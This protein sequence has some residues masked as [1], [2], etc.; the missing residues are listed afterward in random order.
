MSTELYDARDLA[1]Q[2]HDAARVPESKNEEVYA[3]TMQMIGTLI[4]AMD[5]AG[6]TMAEQ[7]RRMGDK[8]S[9]LVKELTVLRENGV[10]RGEDD[11]PRK[12]RPCLEIHMR[13]IRRG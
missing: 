10:L 2:I 13:D 7:R 12:P 11:E 1:D 3:M 4:K 5:E 9:E 6:M 8:T